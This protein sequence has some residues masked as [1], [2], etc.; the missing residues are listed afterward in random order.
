MS[1]FV[2]SRAYL[3]TAVFINRRKKLHSPSYNCATLHWN[4]WRIYVEFNI[5]KIFD[6]Q[7]SDSSIPEAI[8]R[9]LIRGYRIVSANPES[10]H[11][12]TNRNWL[13]K[14][15]SLIVNTCYDYNITRM[16]RLL[17]VSKSCNCWFEHSCK[18]SCTAVAII[19]LFSQR[20]AK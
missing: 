15:V 11:G 8:L 14:F 4:W 5:A 12:K 20:G 17:S 19:W 13:G 9:F 6:K 3:H 2:N 1:N 7:Q 16:P 18:S 10:T